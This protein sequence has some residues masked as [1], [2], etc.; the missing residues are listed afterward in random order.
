[1]GLVDDDGVVIGQHRDALDG[2]DG[3]HGVIG[4]DD[5]GLHGDLAALGREAVGAV[6]ALHLADALAA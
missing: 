2:M 6:G 3:E 5:V 4:H 1:M